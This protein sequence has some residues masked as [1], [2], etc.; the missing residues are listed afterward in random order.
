MKLSKNF[1]L[2]E[3]T[4]SSTATRLKIIN[5]PKTEHLVN[6]AVLTNK[7]LQPVRDKFGVVTV[8]SGYRSPQLN[9]AVGGSSTSQHCNGEAADIECYSI[10]NKQ[11][12]EWI[13]DNLDFDQIILEFYDPR[14]PH[15]GW[16][17]VSNKIDGSN[18]KKCLS[19]VRENGKLIYK[20]GFVS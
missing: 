6:L 18:R 5:N 15:S 14:D 13:R 7:I 12:A 17:H 9:K 2:K 16:I 20:S 19:A 3:M 10:P 4:A 11:L 8:N 1:S